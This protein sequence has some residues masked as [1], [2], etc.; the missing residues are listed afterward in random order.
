MPASFQLLDVPF[1]QFIRVERWR[2]PG[3]QMR[4]IVR[5]TDSVHGLIYDVDRDAVLAACEPRVAMLRED[6]PTAESTGA[7]AGRFDVDLGAES[8]L[9]KEAK[10]EVGATIT[11]ADVILLNQGVP[12]GMS[13]GVLTERAHLARVEVSSEA[14][15]EEE[16]VYGA[17]EEGEQITRVWIPVS[18]LRTMVFHDLSLFALVQNFLLVRAEIRIKVL[19]DKY[20]ALIGK[21]RTHAPELLPAEVRYE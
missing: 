10:E 21:L 8:L 1:E 3:D 20:E 17:P 19:E 9:V 7:V 5:T 4:I 18:E 11:E 16:R 13:P 2:I 12:L 14:I 6:N 15:D